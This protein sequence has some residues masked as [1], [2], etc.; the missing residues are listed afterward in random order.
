[1]K[2]IN[3]I[4]FL[5]FLS[6]LL[7]GCKVGNDN[8]VIVTDVQPGVYVTGEATAFTGEAPASQLL[9]L[10]DYD[11]AETEVPSNVLAID[12]WLKA[13]APFSIT[14]SNGG[15]DMAKYGNG[16]EVS[17]TDRSSIYTL[18]AGGS[19]FTVPADGLYRLLVDTSLSQIH[20]IPINWGVIGAAT[21]GAWDKETP[22][23][24]VTYNEGGFLATFTA[25]VVLTAGEYKFRYSG[26]WG[27]TFTASSG[28]LK[29]HTNIGG[30]NAGMTLPMSGGVI[31][32]AAGGQNLAATSGGEYQMTVTYDLRTR[33]YKMS[34]KI[35][36]EP[37]P[38][39]AVTLPTEMF[40]IGSVN[41]WDW[42]NAWSL[43]PVNGFV[44]PNG[45]NGQSKYWTIRYF[46]AGDEFKFN[47]VKTWEG[48]TEFGFA[49][50]TAPEKGGLSDNGGN[51]K[52]GT[53]GWYIVVVTTTLSE[54]GASLT[55]NVE[56]FD[57]NVYLIGDTIGGWD[58]PNDFKFT[59]PET[60]DGEF[61][62]PALTTDGEVRIAIA[63][64]GIDWWRTEFI[65]LD[66]KIAFRGNEG[67]QTRVRGAA[68]DKVYLNFT[69]GTG[70]IGEGGSTPPPAP[71]VT[72]PAEMYLIGSINGWDWNKA[73]ALVPVNGYVGPN[74]TG[75][76]S[77]Y[78]M[79]RHFN[80]GD[81]FKLNGTKAWD[82][83]EFGFAAVSAPEKGDL[84]DN[85]GNIKV[86]TAGWYILLVTNTLSE[87]GSA[88]TN[89]VR[90]LD[91]DIYLLGGT[92]GEVWDIPNDFK[93]AV[94]EAADGE[95]VSPAMTADG[96]VRMAIV[97]DG[98]DWWRTEFIV[99]D[100]K[101]A[102]RGNGGDQ[103][104]VQASA[105]NKVYLKFA[106]GTGRIE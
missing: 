48:G 20:I 79:I 76:K 80:A 15:E 12:T 75:G 71:A 49:A 62:S 8:W 17:S 97:L 88:V 10:K 68:G 93:F 39:P 63:L 50:V 37:T 4:P 23:T 70:R 38:P 87:D 78:W 28:D 103:E 91:P 54:D 7:F 106:D 95:F 56:L 22:L 65:I 9:T 40:L 101:I 72:L 102:F 55:N 2:K 42:N 86:G 60:A 59:V 21:P 33:V 53:A 105:G 30:A 81:E 51:I 31:D 64:E 99:L 67:D 32:G 66:G 16:G 47:N 73:E 61:V 36:G 6:T 26:D 100:G 13:G 94:P 82:K 18:S 58:I 19:E 104:R 1:M 83:N 46:N 25:K 45:T 34:A 35:L 24:E 27:Y 52:V 69:E 29:Y 11:P 57:P 85:G 84:S 14:I 96:E 3:I 98:I 74:G 41:G 44:G 5:F 90:L 89:D 77:M 92:V 43:I